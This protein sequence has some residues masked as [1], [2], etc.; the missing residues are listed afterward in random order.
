M[1][2]EPTNHLDLEM[3][4]ALTMALQAFQGAILIVSHDRHLLKNTVDT[5]WLV[6]NGKVEEFQGD[7]HDYEDWLLA[8]QSGNKRVEKAEAGDDKLTDSQGES[9][10]S[11]KERKRIAAQKRKL[12]SPLKKKLTKTEADMT[13]HQEQLALLEE[14]L[15][16]SALYQSE[17]K[18]K[19]KD[20]LDQQTG[21]KQA[22]DNAELIWFELSEEIEAAELED[23]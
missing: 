18:A 12:L 10:E 11:K 17:N 16:D 15:A 19:L 9:A 14:V 23:E 7:L 20:V 1:L 22:L 21:Y 13:S 8:Y 5:F 4:H 2:D 3:R 6:A